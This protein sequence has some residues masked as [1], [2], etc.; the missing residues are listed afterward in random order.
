[1]LALLAEVCQDIVSFFLAER[2]RPTSFHSRPLKCSERV[3]TLKF[4]QIIDGSR[5]TKQGAK[6]AVNHVPC[7]LNT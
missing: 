4:S 1:M 6:R 5:I 3:F 7:A 2:V